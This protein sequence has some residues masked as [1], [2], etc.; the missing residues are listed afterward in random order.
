MI[1][2]DWIVPDWPAPRTLRAVST[3]PSGGVSVPPYSSMNPAAH[4]GDAEI[5]VAR[6]RSLLVSELG[7]PSAPYWLQQVHGNKVVAAGQGDSLPEADAAWTATPGTVC[8]VLT[9]DCLP[10]LL[11][12][13]GGSCVA[14]IHAGWRGLAAGVI[15]QAVA[16]LPVAPDRLLA[17][18]GPA[19]GPLAFVV[20][21]EVR[22]AF[23]GQLASASAAFRPATA[24]GWH[25]D[26]YRLARQRLG[27]LGVARVSGGG[28][29]TYRDPERF[30]SY[31]R[32]S[33]TGRMATLIW[34]AE[35]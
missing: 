13:E 24:G 23:I 19:I 20:G 27:L 18:L 7:L 15:E 9:A 16:A 21:D 17:W 25:A 5:A 30:F 10:V 3:T 32:D 12:D 31:R 14:A 33:V 35:A 34:L 29:C 6:N 26:L 8:A 11:C 28:W 22:E 1:V 4:V 2:H